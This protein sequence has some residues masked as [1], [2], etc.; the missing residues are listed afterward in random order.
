MAQKLLVILFF[1]CFALAEEH[2][3]GKDTFGTKTMRN[4]RG[5]TI[6]TKDDKVLRRPNRNFSNV[7]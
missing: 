1:A 3:Y 4:D 2:W 6:V 7:I 5:V